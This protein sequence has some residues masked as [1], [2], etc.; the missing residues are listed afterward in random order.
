MDKLL[1]D[2]M[3]W[4][5]IEELVYSESPDPHRILGAH[6]TE[7]GMLVQAFIPTARNITVRLSGTGKT[8]PMEMADE[9][10]IFRSADSEKEYS[11]IHP[12][13]GLR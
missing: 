3:D 2:L 7:N 8:Y 12:A 10:G 1:Y 9:A 13:C 4:A 6:L 5:G 11:G